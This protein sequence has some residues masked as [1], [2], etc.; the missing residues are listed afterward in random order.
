L[1]EVTFSIIAF[2]FDIGVIKALSQVLFFI[3]LSFSAIS[4]EKLLKIHLFIKSDACCQS[5]QN[6]FIVFI[7]FSITVY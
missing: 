3:S 1:L 4:K 6:I 2:V 5:H 7:V